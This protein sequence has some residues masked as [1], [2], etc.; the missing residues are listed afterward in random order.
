MKNKMILL[1]NS[2]LLLALLLFVSMPYIAAILFRLKTPISGNISLLLS[3]GTSIITLGGIALLYCRITKR[4]FTK[5]MV[6]KKISIKQVMLVMMLAIGTY[7]FAV[8]INSLSMKLF[9]IAIKDS[10]AMSSL[11][12]GS[13]TLLGLFVVI[14]VPAF[15]EEV[16]F[17]GI[18][19][20]AYEGINKK[21]KYFII[22]AIFAT[23]HGNVMQ[24]IYVLFLGLILLK[25]R[26]YTGSLLGS[27]TLH[28]ANNAISFILSKV[29][30]NYMKLVDTGIDNGVIDSAKTAATA[31]A[32]N[33]T[34]TVALLRASIFFLIGGAVL[35][36][37]LRK[38]KEY[39][40]EKEDLEYIQEENV[41][42]LEYNEGEQCIVSD[43][44]NINA[45]KVK[46]VPLAI[47]FVAMTVLVV[48]RY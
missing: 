36:I 17:R 11:L 37:Y 47:Y 43:E 18:F 31:E 21:M 48:L 4:R 25:V 8:G 32:M 7:I 33:V 1:A 2:L 15:F 19:L 39:K 42:S 46:Y 20:D 23:F 44:K 13:S 45:N 26:E 3:G 27:M 24:I 30:L 34:L 35:F 9:P 16:F 10:M 40:E 5:V 6:I 14:L 28:A 22:I 12:N 41:G 38:L 29:A